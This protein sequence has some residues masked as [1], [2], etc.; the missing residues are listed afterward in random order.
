MP[1]EPLVQPL[2][3]ANRSWTF[4][5]LFIVFLLAMPVFVFYA[6]GY[7]IDFGDTRNI[8]TVGG[9]YISADADDVEMFV[10]E[11][12]VTNMRIFQQAAYIQ[13]LEAGMHRVH[14]SRDGLHTWVK[15]L[16][17]YSHIVTEAAAFNMPLV[18]QIR[19]IPMWLDA[20][21]RPVL[22]G[23]TTLAA[24]FPNATTT[25]PVIATSTRV[26]VGFV[27]NAEREYVESLFDPETTDVE[28]TTAASDF[29]FS[30]DPLA[31]QL[32]A[33]TTT[34]EFRNMR[35]FETDGEVYA[36]WVGSERTL[37]FYFCVT[38]TSAATTT[39]EYGAHVYEDLVAEFATSTDLTAP[40]ASGKRFCRETIR[41]DRIGQEVAWF[42]FMPDNEHLVL[43]HLDDGLYVVEIDDRA[44]QNVQLLYPGEDI[45]VRVDG[46]RIYIFDGTYYFEVLTEIT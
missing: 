14:V 3:H 34:R 6:V 2:S 44:W 29:L 46:G 18:P 43:M 42:D 31:A 38:H 36:T 25:N 13:N 21:G 1:S 12:P 30:D 5:I 15:E 32:A 7:R 24:A 26:E 22:V 35:L 41:I 16:P 8:V 27:A 39:H 37:P 4:R 40:S 23:G 33:A 11:E 28:A 9:L 17:V 45:E 19:F 20:S 10:D